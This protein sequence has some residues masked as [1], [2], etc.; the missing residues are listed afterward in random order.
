MASKPRARRV[1]P[2]QPEGEPG[3]LGIDDRGNVTWEWADD[4]DL[5][6]DDT[7]GADRRIH[8]LADPNLRLKDDE[9]SRS[10]GVKFGYNPYDSGALVKERWR[11]KRSLRELSK[12]VELRRKMG[13]THDDAE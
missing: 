13:R 11:R 6:A 10:K 4:E 5:L 3:H 9:P 7:C 2:G 12:W 1:A 8:A